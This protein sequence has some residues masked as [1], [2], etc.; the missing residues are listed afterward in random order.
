MERLEDDERKA[1][2]DAFCITQAAHEARRGEVLD[3][4]VKKLPTGQQAQYHPEKG[5]DQHPRSSLSAPAPCS[6][7]N[8]QNTGQHLKQLGAITQFLLQAEARL[9]L[10]M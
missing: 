6:R 7:A 4:L 3:P 2:N 10:N 9:D 1:R 8:Q 5:K